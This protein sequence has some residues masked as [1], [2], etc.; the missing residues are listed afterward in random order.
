M[1]QIIP[2]HKGEGG[3]D[4]PDHPQAQARTRQVMIQIMVGHKREG[5][6]G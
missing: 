1:I 2:R 5:A 3:R 4:D 6:G